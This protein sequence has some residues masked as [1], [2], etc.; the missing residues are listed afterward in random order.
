MIFCYYQL[1]LS[2]LNI[3][4]I[5]CDSIGKIINTWIDYKS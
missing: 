3:S 4:S 1:F 2:A 5:P